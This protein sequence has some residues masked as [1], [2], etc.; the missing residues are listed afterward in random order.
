MPNISNQEKEHLLE[1]AGVKLFGGSVGAC[2][3]QIPLTFCCL[4]FAAE[5]RSMFCASRGETPPESS[6]SPA[7]RGEKSGECL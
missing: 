1:A 3:S 6:L 2:Q 5:V 7:K 4:V